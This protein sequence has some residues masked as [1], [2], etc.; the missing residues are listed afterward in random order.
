M[1]HDYFAGVRERRRYVLTLQL[2]VITL[3][4]GSTVNTQCKIE[5][6]VARTFG[7]NR[8]FFPISSASPIHCIAHA[9]SQNRVFSLLSLYPERHRK[10]SALNVSKRTKT[11]KQFIPFYSSSHS[12]PLLCKVISSDKATS[13]FFELLSLQMKRLQIMSQ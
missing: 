8:H 6:E 1:S 11:Q 2:G 5:R 7:T 12:E 10:I 9:F 4:A 13:V 3:E